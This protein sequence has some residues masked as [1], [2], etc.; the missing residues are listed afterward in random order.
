MD[1]KQKLQ[2]LEQ[3][4]QSQMA[5]IQQIQYNALRLEGAISILREQITEDEKGDE[6]PSTE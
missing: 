4:H 2:E 3:A 1:K 5:Q 6:S